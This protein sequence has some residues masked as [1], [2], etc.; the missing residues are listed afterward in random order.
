MVSEYQTWAV[1][2]NG[3]R[4]LIEASIPLKGDEEEWKKAIDIA[5]ESYNNEFIPAHNKSR[6]TEVMVLLMGS[7]KAGDISD[8]L[9]EARENTA[10][11]LLKGFGQGDG[12]YSGDRYL[13]IASKCDPLVKKFLSEVKKESLV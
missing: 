8:E 5:L 6:Q 1:K 12:P 7:K 10:G 13:E 4:N 9:T 11:E 3:V 2:A